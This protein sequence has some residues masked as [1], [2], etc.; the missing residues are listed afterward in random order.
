MAVATDADYRRDPARWGS[1]ETAAHFPGFEHLDMRTS[2]AVILLR[3]V[4][5]E[6]HDGPAPAV[7]AHY[8]PR[9]VSS[10]S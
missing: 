4:E 6:R 10:G 5:I 3:L 8:L 7:T 2:G 9:L 1:A